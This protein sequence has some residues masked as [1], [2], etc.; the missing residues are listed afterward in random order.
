MDVEKQKIPFMVEVF[1]TAV[2]T[3]FIDIETTEKVRNHILRNTDDFLAIE[4]VA[5]TNFPAFENLRFLYED[6][7][8]CDDTV[9]PYL[10]CYEN[11]LLDDKR[12]ASQILSNFKIKTTSCITFSLRDKN[13]VKV[14]NKTVYRKYWFFVFSDTVLVFIN[15]CDKP[16][17]FLCAL[18]TNAILVSFKTKIVERTVTIYETSREPIEY[19][20]KYN[21]VPDSKIYSLHWEVT[22]SDGS[23]SF[24]GGLKPEN[25]PLHFDLEYGVVTI[26]ICGV[27]LEYGFSNSDLAKKFA[28]TYSGY[29]QDK[30]TPICDSNLKQEELYNEAL[31]I[32]K[33]VCVPVKLSLFE[34]Y[35]S[36]NPAMKFLLPILLVLSGMFSF[37]CVIFLIEI[38]MSPLI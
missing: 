33:K 12:E 26:S 27:N 31:T 22:N 10:F 25:N 32:V 38:I 30:L 23:R 3:K 7:L 21:P 35:K 2:K 9:N 15:P 17:E 5:N 18:K 11:I 6:L 28:D 13:R 24:R 1:S 19:Y 29:I 36:L 4:E 37:A 20:T 16:V 34:K 8:L 14:K